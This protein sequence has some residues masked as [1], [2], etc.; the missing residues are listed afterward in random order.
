V[1]A[2]KQRPLPK[3]QR[4]GTALCLSG[5]G[6]RTAL[7][8]LGAVRRLNELGILPQIAT[9]SAV[10]GGSLF[11]AFLAQHL[12]LWPT[13]PLPNDEWERRV[14]VPFRAF[15]SVNLGTRP[16][17]LGLLRERSNAGINLMMSRLSERLT[18]MTLQELPEKPRFV[19]G[20]SDLVT[21]RYRAF[22][23]TSEERWTVARVVAASSCTPG[24]YAPLHET[25]PELLALADG[26]VIDNSALEP[27][28][29]THRIL[30]VSD[31]SDGMAAA[32][33]RWLM[34]AAVRSAFVAWNQLRE[35]RTRWLLAGFLSGDMDGAYWAIDSSASHYPGRPPGYS[36]WMARDVL[37]NVRT[38]Y[39]VFSEA[40]IAALENHGY[41]LADAATRA[42]VPLLRTVDAPLNAPHPAWLAEPKVKE[43]LR[44]SAGLVP[45]RF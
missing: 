33:P 30:L 19:F 11:A 37:A 24:F 15:V 38:G 34:S 26:G 9:V 6:F 36:A 31:G 29:R 41:L 7:F 5:G 25:D 16:V 23:R 21:G 39:D 17:V 4:A 32:Y 3:D 2:G 14:G 18:K 35:M 40:E 22:E 43:A 42:H 44:N 27:V 10:S 8:H 20:A 12:R 45:P 1:K 13:A 28:W